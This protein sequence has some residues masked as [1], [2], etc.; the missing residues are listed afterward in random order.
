MMSRVLHSMGVMAVAAVPTVA[1]PACSADAMLVLDLSLSMGES[2]FVEF[3]RPKIDVAREALGT[4][5]REAAPYRDI[6][7]VTYGPGGADQCSGVTVHFSPRP[8]AA[9]PLLDRVTTLAPGGS[10]PLTAAVSAAADTLPRGGEVV[11]ITDGAE[12]C[13]GSPCALA[14]ALRAE[15]DVTVHV[16]GFQVRG[17]FREWQSVDPN[18]FFV[19][20]AASRCLADETGGEYVG[21]QSL[22]ALLAALRETLGCPLFG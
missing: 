8:D 11:L 20:D 2:S 15:G 5:M 12:T 18:D 9:R 13:A 19:T 6:G 22:D 21:A 16:I 3:G 7:L 17:A 14:S 1:L 4:V 10:T